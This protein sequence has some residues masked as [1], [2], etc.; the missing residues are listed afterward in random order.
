MSS[1][2]LF[3]LQQWPLCPILFPKYYYLILYVCVVCSCRCVYMC[4]Y[5]WSLEFH[6]GCLPPSLPIL[7]FKTGNSLIQK[8]ISLASLGGQWTLFNSRHCSPTQSWGIT[9]TQCWGPGV[10]SS[11][12]CSRHLTNRAIFLAP[13][14][15]S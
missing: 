12:L 8:L 11:C 2:T 9:F 4:L 10:R 3:Q 14:F 6:I 15:Q 1:Y 13:I 5:M 7:I